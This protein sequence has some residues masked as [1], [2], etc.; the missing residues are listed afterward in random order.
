MILAEAL[1]VR[2]DLFNEINALAER[3][4]ANVL[5]YE[6]DNLAEHEGAGNLLSQMQE[7]LGEYESMSVAINNTN[8]KVRLSFEGTSM[9]MMEAIALRDRLALSIKRQRAVLEALEGSRGR[10]RYSYEKRTKDDVRQ[11]PTVDQA[12]LR[13]DIDGESARMRALDIEIQ[14]VNW[15]TDLL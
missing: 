12:Q 5:R 1:A 7:K 15:S 9:S 6:D 13:N 4:A 11:V 10:G 2:K 14:K 8:N 3:A